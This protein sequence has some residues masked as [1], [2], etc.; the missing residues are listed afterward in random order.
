MY[1]QDEGNKYKALAYKPN[2]LF[3]SVDAILSAL[4][5]RMS[6][7]C[8]EVPGFNFGCTF[9]H[10]LIVEAIARRASSKSSFLNSS[11]QILHPPPHDVGNEFMVN[12][13]ADRKLNRAR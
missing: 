1:Q 7:V 9:S 6:S 12:R 4:I 13:F 5:L 3:M 11:I 2:S 8:P 10:L